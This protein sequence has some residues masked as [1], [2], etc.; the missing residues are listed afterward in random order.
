MPHSSV[1]QHTTSAFFFFFFPQCQSIY[2]EV[3]QVGGLLTTC[4]LLYAPTRAFRSAL[5]WQ[6][7]GGTSLSRLF[8]PRGRNNMSENKQSPINVSHL[9]SACLLSELVYL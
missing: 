6:Q 5:S 8:F 7:N 3:M 9:F 4:I 2:G 1:D